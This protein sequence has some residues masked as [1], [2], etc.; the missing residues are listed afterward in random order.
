[1][2]VVQPAEDWPH[3]DRPLGRARRRMP[4]LQPQG[5]VRAVAVVGADELL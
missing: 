4:G 2:H 1:M 3:T 5:P